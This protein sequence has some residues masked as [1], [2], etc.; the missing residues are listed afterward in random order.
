MLKEVIKTLKIWIDT[1]GGID[2]ILALIIA[3]NSPEL[4]VVGISTVAGNVRVEKA[5]E[6]VLNFLKIYERTEIPVYIGSEKPLKRDLL[7]AEH[8]HGNDGIGNLNLG[9]AS[10]RP[11]NEN[12]LEGLKKAIE[13]HP[14][15]ISLITLGPLTNIAKFIKNFPDSAKKIKK[16]VIMGGAFFKSGNVTPHA[17]FNIFVDAEA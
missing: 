10:I 1:D 9:P 12:Y 4:D 11:S 3:L 15:E 7:T 8:V 14:K 6:N 13:N 17:E 2:D 16:I 5:T